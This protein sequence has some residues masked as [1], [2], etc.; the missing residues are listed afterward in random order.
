MA[1]AQK[2]KGKVL[3]DPV[4]S[5]TTVAHAAGMRIIIVAPPGK[6]GIIVNLSLD[7]GLP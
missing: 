3:A 6:L 5:E 7:S 1:A 4:N 2:K